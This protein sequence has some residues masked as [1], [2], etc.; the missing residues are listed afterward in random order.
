MQGSATLRLDGP[1][2]KLA[3]PLSGACSVCVLADNPYAQGPVWNCVGQVCTD[4]SERAPSG[5]PDSTLARCLRRAAA[6][7]TCAMDSGSARGRQLTLRGDV[8]KSTKQVMCT[9]ARLPSWCVYSCFLG[10]SVGNSCTRVPVTIRVD[11]AGRGEVAAA[12]GPPGKGRGEAAGQC[13]DAYLDEIRDVLPD[14][15]PLLWFVWQI[16][17]ALWG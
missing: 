12:A 1:K 9:A 7:Q 17:A 2:L 5:T 10:T 6:V 11:S 14:R 8:A 15:P 3:A 13:A 16:G 4:S